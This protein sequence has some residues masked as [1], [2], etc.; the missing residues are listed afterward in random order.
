MNTSAIGEIIL[1]LLVE[2]LTRFNRMLKAK[3]KKIIEYEEAD[4]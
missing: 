4:Y 2:L 1:F 3:I